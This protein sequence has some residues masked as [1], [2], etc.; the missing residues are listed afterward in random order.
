[1]EMGGGTSLLEMDKAR[2]GQAFEL[3]H[4]LLSYVLH[5]STYPGA[6]CMVP[7]QRLMLMG[8]MLSAGLPCS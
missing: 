8:F 4:D 3:R 1:M 5:L 6:V 7:S 2:A